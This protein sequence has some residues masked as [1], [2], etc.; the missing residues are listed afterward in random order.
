MTQT[1]D[2]PLKSKKDVARY[3]G[4]SVRQLDRL[5]NSGGL[6]YLKVGGLVKF[7][8]ADVE[9]FLESCRNRTKRSITG[10]SVGDS[11]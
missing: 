8:P 2:S 10:A 5:T 9:T 1:G 6:P 4:V 7:R 3:I 11:L